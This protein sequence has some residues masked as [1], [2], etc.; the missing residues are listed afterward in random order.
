MTVAVVGCLVAANEGD[1]PGVIDCLNSLSALE[2][3]RMPSVIPH[4]IKIA[5]MDGELFQRVVLGSEYR[6]T[7]GEVYE[8]VMRAHASVVTAVLTA[9]KDQIDWDFLMDYTLVLRKYDLLVAVCAFRGIEVPTQRTLDI[10]SL[11]R[12]NN[13]LIQGNVRFLHVVTQFSLGDE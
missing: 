10:E 5:N 1:M 9:Y 4:I 11:M 7:M 2:P 12:D 3:P 6:M 13:R 8:T